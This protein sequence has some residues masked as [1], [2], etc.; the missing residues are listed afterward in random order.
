MCVLGQDFVV[1][2][3]VEILVYRY[4]TVRV[5]DFTSEVAIEVCVR[6]RGVKSC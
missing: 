2:C 5:D 3:N 4:Y 6:C 1:P